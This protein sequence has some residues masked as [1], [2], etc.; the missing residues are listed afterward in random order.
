MVK[1]ADAREQVISLAL[2][3]VKDEKKLADL[4][5]NVKKLGLPSSADIIADE[6]LK[7]AESK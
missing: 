2:D 5:K 6:V 3:T 7:L 4:A 1:D